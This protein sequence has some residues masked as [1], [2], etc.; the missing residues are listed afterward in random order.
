MGQAHGLCAGH[1]CRRMHT[2]CSFAVPCGVVFIVPACT[3]R[4]GRASGQ[5][6]GGAAAV[7]FLQV[8][9]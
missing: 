5:F 9:C 8:R 3:A 7:T 6:G 1:V 2:S 4:G